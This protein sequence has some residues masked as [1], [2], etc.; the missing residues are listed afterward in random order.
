MQLPSLN[1]L[2][3]PLAPR[4]RRL[5][6]SRTS[7]TSLTA[8]N[9]KPSTLDPEEGQPLL[10]DSSTT[11]RATPKVLAAAVV[12]GLPTIDATAKGTLSV[13]FAGCSPG[14][15]IT[16]PFLPRSSFFFFRLIFWTSLA[17]ASVDTLGHQALDELGL[18]SANAET[19]YLHIGCRRRVA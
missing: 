2:L 12:I 16:S 13:C 15:A 18:C 6:G 3:A 8:L 9:M 17:N 11:R 10:A 4:R 14:G 5:A 7:F 1:I 19:T